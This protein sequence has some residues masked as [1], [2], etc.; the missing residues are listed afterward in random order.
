MKTHLM[1]MGCLLAM[2]AAASAAEPDKGASP[3]PQFRGPDGQGHI[4][5]KA[6]L[7]WGEG[8]NMA[9]KVPVPGKGWSSPVIASGKA[10]VS[11]AV[12]IKGG[13][14]SLRLMGFDLQT[15]DMKHDVELFAAAK[16]PT[17]H[18]RNTPASPTPAVVGDRVIVSF[19]GEGVGCVEAS[20]G[21]VAW[22]NDSLKVN[23]FTG[24]ASSPIPYKDR[25][26]LPCDG[27]DAQFAIAI[28]AASGKQVWKTERTAAVKKAPDERRAFSSP[29]IIQ[30]GGQDQ[31]VMPGAHRVYSYNPDTGEELWTV[32]YVGFSNVPR[33]VFAHG[34]VYVTSGFGA[35][36][37]MAI[38][39]DGRGDVTST[40]V[41]WR[42]KKSV[43]NIPSPM[44][45]GERMYLISDKGVLTCLDA[46][47]GESKFTERLTGNFSA[48]PLA[49]GDAVYLFADESITYVFKAGDSYEQLARNELTGR[50][51]A[52]PAAAN[53]GLLIRT[54]GHLYFV[55]DLKGK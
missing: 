12:S 28:D 19:G 14:A 43:S 55:S 31:V 3:W 1:L 29:L 40:H 22:K 45:V 24:P 35:H 4:Q 50:I 5:G 44:I 26:I 8:K 16:A 20:T 33:T 2:G 27:A 39:P 34:L 53:G 36:E 46:K 17:L 25:V 10:W 38:K 47:T 21:K 9:W 37:L 42:Y 13:G 32:N 7:E 15:G 54:D 49:S 11:T 30:V 23:Y 41:A 52:T 48:S 51:Q 18:A 6:P